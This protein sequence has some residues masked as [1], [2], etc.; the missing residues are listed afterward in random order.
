M[1]TAAAT[2]AAVG[3]LSDDHLREGIER[4][5]RVRQS[6]GEVAL[7]DPKEAKTTF[8]ALILST[9]NQAAEHQI[10]LIKSLVDSKFSDAVKS[11]A[12]SIAGL[13]ASDRFAVMELCY[14]GLRKLKK[15]DQED[16]SDLLQKLADE[17]GQ[18]SLREALVLDVI[19]RQFGKGNSGKSN[20]QRLEK[21]IEKLSPTVSQLL[22]L[23]ALLEAEDEETAKSGFNDA[24]SKQYLLS[25][26][27]RPPDSTVSLQ[28]LSKILSE[29]NKA[30]FAIRKQVLAAA[31]DI[32]LSDNETT[33]R[34]WT[35]LRLVSLSL[36]APMPPLPGN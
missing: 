3:A 10:Q 34:E 31:A 14:P 22:Y 11:R 27:I 29:M 17:D 35:F 8:T 32:V 25:P 30:S 12:E 4:R 19:H 15:S 6:I 2:V 21:N 33:D 18:I 1:M 16:F 24:V 5:I 23:V 28:D 26:S 7:D 20:L 13:S 36:G 9:E